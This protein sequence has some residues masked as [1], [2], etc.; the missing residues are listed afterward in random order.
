[1]GCR[2][3]RRRLPGGGFARLAF[4]GGLLERGLGGF[5]IGGY[6]PGGNFARFALGSGLFQRSLGG[7]AI[8]GSLLCRCLGVGIMLD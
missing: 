6:L 3:I 7:F 1:G 2:A 4:G 5:A 8:G